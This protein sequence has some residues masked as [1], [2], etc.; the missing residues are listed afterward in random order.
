MIFPIALF[1]HVLRLWTKYMHE[2]IFTLYSPKPIDIIIDIEKY[3]IDFF[4]K[5]RFDKQRQVFN[6]FFVFGATDIFK[7]FLILFYLHWGEFDSLLLA[8]WLLLLLLLLTVLPLLIG[9]HGILELELVVLHSFF[10]WKKI[11]NFYFDIKFLKNDEKTLSSCIKKKK[12]KQ[13]GTKFFI[14]CLRRI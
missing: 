12:K 1:I 11:L 8:D 7:S 13:N 3:S 9:V 14:I 4:F 10:I 5:R 2:K 6:I